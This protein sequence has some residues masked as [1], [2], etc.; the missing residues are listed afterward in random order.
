MLW[1]KTADENEWRG[2]C[3]SH[4][5]PDTHIEIDQLK[6]V[7]IVSLVYKGTPLS[8]ALKLDLLVENSVVIDHIQPP[9]PD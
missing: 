2:F 3:L 5:M 7:I 1:L 9:T 8:S 6:E 4:L